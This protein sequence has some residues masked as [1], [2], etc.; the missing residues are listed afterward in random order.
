[1]LPSDLA[2]HEPMVKV[3]IDASTMSD[4]GKA[5]LKRLTERLETTL[6]I[7]GGGEGA[8]RGVD[9]KGLLPEA[10]KVTSVLR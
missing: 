6:P 2:V 3:L 1:M 4:A 7:C 8:H 10:G 5:K 9:R